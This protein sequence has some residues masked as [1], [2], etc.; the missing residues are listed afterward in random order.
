MSD[1]VSKDRPKFDHPDVTATGEPRAKV[2]LRAMETLWFNTGTLCNVTCANCYIESSPLNDRLIY[3]SLADTISFLDEIRDLSLPVKTIGF[4]GGEPFMNPDFIAMLD[5]ALRRGFD[6]QALTNAMKPMRRA[7]E[8]LL[9]LRKTHG[10]ALQIR[11]SIDH[12]TPEV[13]ER[14]RGQG[15]WSSA[16]NGLFWLAQ[17]GFAPH[18]AARQ[19]T[20]ELEDEVRAGFAKL[21]LKTGIRVDAN[22]P[23]RL[24]I[25]PE[26]DMHREVPEITQ[27]CWK[28][29]GKSPEEMMCAS[30]RMVVRRK[31]APAPAVLACTL[32]PYDPQFELGAN[33]ASALRA[34]SLNHP[35]CARFCVIGGGH[36]GGS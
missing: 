24:I 15:S 7:E 35:H 26:M 12:Y 23:G 5:E 3:L 1:R 25:F 20:D 33:L 27:D 13:H 11:V 6:V 17:N 31:G 32:L 4:T 10:K 30:A 29:L 2:A 16:M 19:F 8:E 22:N 28:I 9:M 36:C 34:V 21:F 14:E 18:V